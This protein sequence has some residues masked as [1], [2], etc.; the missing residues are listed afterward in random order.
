MVC[1]RVNDSSRA[2][3]CR[4]VKLRARIDRPM[5]FSAGGRRILRLLILCSVVA[6]AQ[7][8]PVYAQ[9]AESAQVPTT[10]GALQVTVTTQGNIPLGGVV[11]SLLRNGTEVTNSV[12]DG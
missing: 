4:H 11:V 5:Q 12:T 7:A 10:N 2:N 6:T 3:D 1:R 8:L 9:R